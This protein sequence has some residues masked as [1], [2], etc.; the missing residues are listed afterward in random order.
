[1]SQQGGWYYEITGET[2]GP[3]TGAKMKE[4]LADGTIA[5]DTLVRRGEGEWVFADRVAGLF[6]EPEVHRSPEPQM[7]SK[8]EW[9]YQVMG[10]TFGPVTAEQF[11]S[12]AD[13]GSIDRDTL[14]RKGEGGHWAT[15]DHVQG[16]FK[17]AE[18]DTD[19]DTS[20]TDEGIEAKVKATDE[21]FGDDEIVEFFDK[22]PVDGE[23]IRETPPTGHSADGDLLHHF[24]LAVQVIIEQQNTSVQ[25]I[26]RIEQHAK[27]IERHNARLVWALVTVPA[28]VGLLTLIWIALNI[29]SL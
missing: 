4:L 7:S 2:I 21:G 6:A 3:V 23:T 24:K 8:P 18:P 14:I 1:M 28:I 20:M 17:A 16:L 26:T 19:D 29:G 25:L 10:E 11:K 12:L 22:S 27:R 13:E 9:Y 5:L 15:A